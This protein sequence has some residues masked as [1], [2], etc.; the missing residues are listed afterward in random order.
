M[1]YGKFKKYRYPEIIKAANCEDEKGEA[2]KNRRRK[3]DS[4]VF[5]S[6]YYI[7]TLFPHF[8]STSVP[9]KSFSL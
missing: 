6:M 5:K 8:W 2:M 1:F 3:K 9:F 4:L 7:F